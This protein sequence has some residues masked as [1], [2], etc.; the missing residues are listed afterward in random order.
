M[1]TTP[2]I[3]A[4]ELV[5]AQALPET[6]VNEIVRH[7]IQGSSSRIFKSRVVA[8]PPS[9]PAQADEYLVAASPTGAWAGQAGKIAFYLNTGWIFVTPYAGVDA[10]VIDE[11]GIIYYDGSA[12]QPLGLTVLDDGTLAAEQPLG[13]ADA[14]RRADLHRRGD[15]DGLGR[16][17]E[18]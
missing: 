11:A 16:R 15:R 18:G 12:W 14:I 5:A 9:T 17:L 4:P 13:G 3:G 1:T 2:R 8:A 7:L 10:F 6:T